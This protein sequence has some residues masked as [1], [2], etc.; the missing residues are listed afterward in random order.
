MKEIDEV[1]MKVA[2]GVL[3]AIF[4]SQSVSVTL[5]YCIW[6]WLSDRKFTS[7]RV[8]IQAEY[9]TLLTSVLDS[10]QLALRLSERVLS[11]MA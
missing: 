1:P 8:S 9:L 10:S 7:A 5:L 11:P 4:P 2:S 3:L 6:F